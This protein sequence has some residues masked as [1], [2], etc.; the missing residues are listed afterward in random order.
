V[1]LI[2]YNILGQRVRTLV[3]APMTAG[4]YSIAWDGRNEAGSVLSSGVYFYR[5]QAGATALV[6]KML[7]LK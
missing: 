1:S 3:N 4:R 7:L 5:L 2:V 6:K